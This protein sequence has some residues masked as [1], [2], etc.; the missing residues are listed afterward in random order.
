MAAPLAFLLFLVAVCAAAPAGW[1]KRERSSPDTLLQL[2][3]GVRYEPASLAA[4]ESLFWAVSNPAHPQFG[5]LITMEEANDLVRPPVEHTAAVVN[6]LKSCSSNVV[7]HPGGDWVQ[8]TATVS[9]AERLLGVQYSRFERTVG[10]VTQSVDRTE[11]AFVLPEAVKELVTVVEP[12]RR[13]PS[14]H[15]GPRKS[16]A[17]DD[18]PFGGTTPTTIRTAYG[19]GKVEANN[20]ANKQQTAGFL[21]QYAD[22]NGDLQSFFDEYYKV[23]KGRKFEVVGPNHAGDAGDEASLDTQYIMAI[24]SNVPTTFWYTSGERPYQNE[25]YLVW[26]TNVTALADA[27]IPNT[28]SVSYGDNEYQIEPAYAAAVDVLFQKLGVRGSSVVF[29]SGDGGVSGGQSGPCIGPN[30]DEFVPTWPA[31]SSYVTSVG[32]TDITLKAA[33]SFSSG[34]FSNMYPAQPY[35]QS[36]IEYYK[37]HTTG[38]PAASHYNAT[39]RGFPDVSTVGVE[40]WIFVQGLDEPVDGTSCA[41]PTF[42]GI[43][44]LLN[45]A[46][47]SAGKKPLGFLNQILY[48]H[49]EVFT[50][51][52]QGNNPGCGTKGFPAAQGWDPITGL[53]TPKYPEMLALALQ[54]P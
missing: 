20:T 18:N 51:I 14:S 42:T 28:I 25:P 33:A 8:A 47:V 17:A 41:A 3:I 1:I 54:L 48:A 39:G 31:G 36:A 35:Q 50:D 40:F 16:P 15:S 24:G 5:Q 46:R 21:G 2:T 6:W 19:L 52:T 13:F 45:D 34:G 10:T 53:G 49:P 26:L 9:C 11:D 38:L 7:P 44:S 43:V 37:T 32:A 30:G 4:L 22:P 27:D 29:A 23:A 12:A